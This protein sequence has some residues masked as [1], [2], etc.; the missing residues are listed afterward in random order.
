MAV[1][2]GDRIIVGAAPP[3]FG[4]SLSKP[5]LT[6]LPG[7][8]FAIAWSLHEPS[9]GGQPADSRSFIRLYDSDG[10]TGAMPL[11]ELAGGAL[12]DIAASTAG[13]ISVTTNNGGHVV[14]A[15]VF[16]LN[17]RPIADE[18]P[19]FDPGSS[20][21]YTHPIS[22]AA[23]SDGGYAAVWRWLDDGAHVPDW[24][25]QLRLVLPSGEAVPKAFDIGPNAQSAAQAAIVA[26]GEV[27][28]LAGIG[29][30]ADYRI[31]LFRYS[32][33][34]EL[35]AEPTDIRMIGRELVTVSDFDRLANGDLAVTW[36]RHNGPSRTYSA[37]TE[38]FDG[39]GN[40][41]GSSDRDSITPT[42]GIAPQIAP[43]QDGGYVMAW[44][45]S[46]VVINGV[47]RR[48]LMYQ[49]FD[50]HDVPVTG[51]E[52]AADDTNDIG[53]FDIATLDD[54]RFVITYE[55]NGGEEE[56]HPV[57]SAQVFD[58]APS[59]TPA[60]GGTIAIVDSW[61]QQL[62]IT[63]DDGIDTV[64]T[65]DSFA[66][67]PFIPNLT[68][69]GTA[70]LNADGNDMAN[71]LIGNDGDNIIVGYL[72]ND[73][74]H[75]HRGNDFLAMGRGNDV[76]DGGEGD[77]TVWGGQG[78]DSVAGG[79]GDDLLN[80]DRHDDVLDGGA[81][82][83]SINGGAH[84]DLLTGADGDDSITGGAG[85]DTLEGGDGADT[86]RG[87]RDDDTLD[88]GDGPDSFVFTSLSGADTILDFEWP[89]D[90]DDRDRIVIEVDADSTIN[91]ILIESVADLWARSA[92]SL[93]GFKVDL[94]EG[95]S[96]TLMG[97][98]RS[99]LSEDMFA[100][101]VV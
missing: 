18:Q 47:G 23:M 35:L 14:N 3:E 83:D 63:R 41:L 62:E 78:N 53:G 54:G 85:A 37:W 76:A 80:G 97:Q 30:S 55:H 69:A 25:S 20:S 60:P 98:I 12:G 21:I 6:A 57:I 17:G 40:P 91:G 93:H 29:T 13:T 90:G 33:E 4:Y 52:V 100:L 88:G 49:V 31:A 92:D 28:V 24:V 34:D 46:T 36:L 48:A 26:D 59:H 15:Q 11:V 67:A 39:E 94:G 72:G 99:S 84:D 70:E 5:L 71:F 66:L 89:G 64:V 38:R 19:I 2:T 16:D 42:G 58:H 50:R 45:G 61:Q 74:M 8:G 27:K 81:G 96:I 9:V 7:D 68:M 101:V 82:D 32:A 73:V 86:L 87:D 75:G 56:P 77:D 44:V 95:H 1:I 43:L 51:A 22:L 10:N 79:D 65:T